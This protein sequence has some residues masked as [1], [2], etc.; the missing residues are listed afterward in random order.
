[1]RKIALQFSDSSPPQSQN[2]LRKV[3]FAG[4][5]KHQIQLNNER[6]QF[7]EKNCY[8][9][10]YFNT[11]FTGYFE[12]LVRTGKSMFFV[13]ERHEKNLQFLHKLIFQNV[14]VTSSGCI[15]LCR[16][17]I[18]IKSCPVNKQFECT[19]DLLYDD[20]HATLHEETTT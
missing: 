15:Q 2:K 17:M 18:T 16:R 20:A 6:A 12:K 11:G 14:N 10:S 8:A 19:V 13:E 1:M 4:I 7:F 5:Q 9:Y 3:F